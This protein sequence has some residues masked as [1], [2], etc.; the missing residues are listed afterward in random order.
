MTN[1]RLRSGA[2]ALVVLAAPATVALLRATLAGDLPEPLPVH[3]DASGEVDET[4]TLGGFTA[5]VGAVTAVGAALTLFL[6]VLRSRRAVAP[7][8]VVLGGWL[9]W[10]FAAVYAQVLLGAQ[11]AATAAEVELGWLAVVGTLLVPTALAALLWWLLPRPEV[12]DPAGPPASSLTVGPDERV[13]WLGTARSRVLL[14]GGAALLAA[15]SVLALRVTVEGLVLA[16]TGLLLALLSSLTVRVDREAVTVRWGI[17]PLRHRLPLDSLVAARTEE[18]EPMRWGGWGYRASTRGRAA[19]V[20]R[21]PG[22]VL[23][24]RDGREFAVTVD[25]PEQGAELVNA[26]LAARRTPAG[27][28][29]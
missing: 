4:A 2:A 23:T 1:P 3:W 16:G 13:V 28:A 22:L 11:G 26:L 19:V 25:R 15:G 14:V 6:L 5:A 8:A 12:A 17:L 27:D 9:T 29:H 10:V 21:G 24:L 7:E 18:V 20:R